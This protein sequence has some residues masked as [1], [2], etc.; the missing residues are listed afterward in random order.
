MIRKGPP[1]R[2]GY[3][4]RNRKKEAIPGLYSSLRLKS[5][6]IKQFGPQSDIV[7]II[8]EGSEQ[9]VKII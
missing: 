9:Y 5:L 6:Q 7:R 1:G 2:I 4:S 3:R 8:L